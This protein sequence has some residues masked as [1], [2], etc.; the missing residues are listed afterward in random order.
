MGHE[1]IAVIFARGGSKG[2]PKK[3]IL[4]LDGKSLLARAIEVG[5]SLNRVKKVVVSTDSEEIASLALSLGAE[6][7][8]LRPAILA[9]DEAPEW[10]AWRHAVE[11]LRCKGE[12]F[13]SLLSLPPTAPLRSRDDVECCLD[14]FQA[15]NVDGVITVR[16]SD[17]NP[18]FNVV[19][20]DS[21][22]FFRLVLD[23]KFS[24]RQDA[25]IVY[26][27]TTVAYVFKA[28]FILS[29]DRLFDGKLR[30][31][32][33]PRDRAIDIDTPFDMA[34]AKV[35]SEQLRSDEPPEAL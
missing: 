29:A 33:I 9:T 34:V 7:P 20:K 31:V 24:R 32:K 23:G 19:H 2:L 12:K 28:D 13:D 14:M 35:V 1:I 17:R 10:L 18:Y 22:N 3:N 15:N 27:M 4:E 26:E 16:E 21:N 5:Q 11:T 25:P 6:V 30:A 8:F